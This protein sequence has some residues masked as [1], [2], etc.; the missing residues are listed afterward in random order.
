MTRDF[1]DTRRHI[2]ALRL[3][4]QGI[5]EPA[6]ERPVD[7][8]RH[9]LAMQAQ[10]FGGAKWSVGLRMPRSS[11]E[12]IETALADRS[13]VR[14]WPMRGTLHFVAAEDLRWIVGLTGERTIRSAA[15]R[16]RALGLDEAVLAHARAT[17]EKLLADGPVARSALLAALDGAGIS[18]EGQRGAHL[19]V[20]LAASRVTVFGPVAGKQHTFA[21][22]DDWIHLSRDLS[23]D[24]A[25]AEF[26]VRY[27]RS[28]GPATIRDFA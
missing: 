2:T 28:H 4:A 20:W 11:D 27:F 18:T 16:H 13:I 19:L 24:E 6:F 17:A 15:G 5:A 7:V 1:G 3:T 12:Q 26:V 23:G 22:F 8:V 21:L 9:L 14:S 25:L 10:D